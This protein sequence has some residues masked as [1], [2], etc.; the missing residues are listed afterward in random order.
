M[1]VC[2][3]SDS[4]GYAG[5]MMTAIGL[6]KPDLCFFLGDGER[7][8]DRVIEK[9]PELP[10]YAVKGNCDF[11]TELSSSLFCEVEG[12]KIFATHG[13][14]SR[15]KYDFDLETLTSQAAEAGAHTLPAFVREPWYHTPESGHG[16]ERVLSVLCGADDRERK[17]QR[18]P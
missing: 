7:D 15:V 13:H 16:R 14:L 9:Y 17:I 12:V 2:V 18:R 11:R 4:H 8:I 5:N 6:E 1:K 3:F 10:V